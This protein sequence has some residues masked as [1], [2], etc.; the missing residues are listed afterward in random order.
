MIEDGE[1][2]EKVDLMIPI[3][4]NLD[5]AAAPPGRQLMITGSF[6]TIK[7]DW[8]AW[9]AAGMRSVESVFPGIK[10]HILFA[11]TTRPKAWAVSSAKSSG[12]HR[13]STRSGPG[14]VSS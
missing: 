8:K 14:W 2:P 13:P 10:K 9:E 11:E 5:P 6:P 7:A 4:S 1:V 3:I 12:L